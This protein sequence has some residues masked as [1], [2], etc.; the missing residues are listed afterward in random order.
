MKHLWTLCG[1]ILLPF[2]LCGQYLEIGTYLGTSTY[3]GDLSEQKLS[4]D[5]GS[6]LGIFAR[7][8]MSKT[9]SVKGS[10]TRGVIKGSDEDAGKLD[11]QMRNLSFRS[12]VVELAATGE[13]NLM[14]YNIRDKKTAVPYIFGG[15][16]LFHFNPQAQFKGEWLDLAP[17]H[18]EAQSYKKFQVAVPF[19][20]GFKFNLSYK[21]NFGLEFGMRKTFTDYLDDVSGKYPD[22]LEMRKTDP[23]AASLS[24][25]T[26]ELT[27]SFGEN[28]VGTDRGNA[29]N[30]DWYFFGGLTISVNMTDKY[31]LDFDEKY[32]VFKEHL[33]EAKEAKKAAIEKEKLKSARYQKKKRKKK[34]KKKQQLQAPAKKRTN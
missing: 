1:M 2:L 16:A 9:F 7:Y 4:G 8:N 34:R 13:L 12:D 15:I 33:V 17:L 20:L 21:V 27:G 10:F 11:I 3:I 29:S 5:F 18:T 6:T 32:D 25:R 23:L 31:G 26:P 24:Y 22:I 28:P 19:G 14:P 30:D